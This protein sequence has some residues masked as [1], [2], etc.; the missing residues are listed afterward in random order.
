MTFLQG[1]VMLIQADGHSLICMLATTDKSLQLLLPYLLQQAFNEGCTLSAS[2]MLTRHCMCFDVGHAAWCIQVAC[3]AV[4]ALGTA[5]R[6]H[7]V[8]MHAYGDFSAGQYDAH[9]S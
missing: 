6:V 5:D 7:Y 4:E 1:G 8:T 3:V 9:T 2:Q